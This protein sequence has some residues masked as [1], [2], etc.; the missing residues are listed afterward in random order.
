MTSTVISVGYGNLYGGYTLEDKGWGDRVA[1]QVSALVALNVDLFVALELHEENDMNDY[2]L[3]QMPAGWAMM[4]GDGGNH[5]LYKTAKIAPVQTV[6]VMMPGDRAASRWKVRNIA[7]GLTFWVG[8]THFR[9]ND[10][11]GKSRAKE[12]AQEAAFM[13]AEMA[14]VKK[15]LALFAG[16]FNSATYSSGYPR[17]IFKKG[18]WLGLKDRGSVTRGDYD[19][20]GG[21]RSGKW[22]D[23]IMTKAP[24]T[25]SG[26]ALVDVGSLSDHDWLKTTIDFH[27]IVAAPPPPGDPIDPPVIVQPPPPWDDPVP[28]PEV[29]W[30][31]PVPQDHVPLVI[32]VWSKDFAR[33][34][35][36]TRPL[37]VDGSV[38]HNGAGTFQFTVD[39]DHPRI[40]ELTEPGARA[41]IIYR[42]SPKSTPIPIYSGRLATRAGAGSRLASTRTFTVVDDWTILSQILGFPNPTGTIAQQ[43]DDSAYYTRTGDAETVLKDIVAVNA[44]RQSVTLDVPTPTGLGQQCS[45]SVRMHPLPD[46]LFPTIDQAGLAVRI[47]QQGATRRLLVKTPTLRLRPLTED[48]GAVVDNDFTINDPTV[49][50]V[51][52]GAGGE[53]TAR[54]FR[55]YVDDEREESFG[56][57]AAVFVDA[58]DVAVDDPNLEATLQA[59]AAEALAAGDAKTSL[60]VVLAETPTFRFGKTFNLSDQISVQPSGGPVLT[61]IVREVHFSYTETAGL[62]ITPIVGDWSDSTNQEL[63]DAVTVLSRSVRDNQR[64]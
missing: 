50:R 27:D 42:Y 36:I 52:V 29:I 61:D 48:S 23:D 33:R 58:R 20:H 25:L 60:R 43:G 15:E 56:F 12:R 8:G 35:L 64:R 34:A 26:S 24:L 4:E 10:T 11:D 18:G 19:S 17:D 45:V 16:D 6:N 57:S 46:R 39:A 30:S 53:G 51:V 44:A 21:G 63:Y 13:V 5:L 3:A 9:A 31:D 47:L 2:F 37:S 54:V 41:V 22:I 40:G 7:T 32:E 59:R 1:G 62:E 14:K 38:I 49:T 28:E 55:E